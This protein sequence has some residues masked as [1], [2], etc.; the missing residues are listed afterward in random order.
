[1]NVKVHIATFGLSTVCGRR[2]SDSRFVTRP[3]FIGGYDPNAVPVTCKTCL[4]I[5]A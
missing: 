3:T 5:R 4:R 2:V 1:M